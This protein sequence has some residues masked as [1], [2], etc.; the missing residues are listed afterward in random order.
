MRIIAA[1]VT[2][3]AATTIAAAGA[4]APARALA[5]TTKTDALTAMHDEALA[6]ADYRAFAAQAESVGAHEV[7]VLFHLVANQERDEHFTEL[8]TL[9]G[10]VGSSRRNLRTAIAAELTEATTIYPGY[11][12]V[13]AAEG[14]AAAVDLF[15][16]LARDEGSHAA[17]L[18]KAYQ[19]LLGTAQPPAPPAPNEV[20]IVTDSDRAAGATL[21]NVR[22][23]MRGEAFASAR[24]R[25]F[26]WQ[27]CQDG[28]PWLGKLLTT[29]SGLELGE[30]YAELANRYG[31][32]R[33]LRRNL[34]AVIA[35]EAKA[36]EDYTAFA[37][38]ARTAGDTSAADRFA[39]IATDENA[40]RAMFT[41][42]LSALN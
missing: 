4:A 1:L 21:V 31:L 25:M 17:V 24:Y 5:P 15:G 30:H 26:A 37:A 40:H 22:A 36:V 19:A 2:V 33:S 9:A 27:S 23:A 29:L 41:A 6:F 11:Q 3:A 39:E 16:E 28:E 18:A 13:A 34:S 12:R 14:D 32:V 42:A 20:R 10:T 8:S 35:E 7:A 38:T